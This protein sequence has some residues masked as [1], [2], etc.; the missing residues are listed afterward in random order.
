MTYTATI[1]AKSATDKDT[2][3]IF[4]SEALL[5]R[6]LIKDAKAAFANVGISLTKGDFVNI[7]FKTALDKLVPAANFTI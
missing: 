2:S 5:E 3:L 4:H 1:F 6:D 7:T